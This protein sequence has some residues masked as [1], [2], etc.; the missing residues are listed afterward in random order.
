MTGVVSSDLSAE[1][2]LQ[3]LTL[4]VITSVADFGTAQQA[5]LERQLCIDDGA[6]GLVYQPLEESKKVSWMSML[7]HIKD[8]GCATCAAGKY[9]LKM[10][11]RPPRRTTTGMLTCWKSC[12]QSMTSMLF[13]ARFP[14]DITRKMYTHW[15][16]VLLVVRP[17]FKQEN[18]KIIFIIGLFPSRNRTA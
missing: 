15:G 11:C 3:A 14:A 12:L 13:T 8:S 9:H 6:S 10:S 5:L 2:Q 17:P 7:E 16:I 18:C 4:Q 1:T